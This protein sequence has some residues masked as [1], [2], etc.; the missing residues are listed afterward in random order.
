MPIETTRSITTTQA[1]QLLIT[2][3]AGLRE[4]GPPGD[5][6]TVSVTATVDG[7]QASPA[8]TTTTAPTGLHTQAVYEAVR[9]IGAGRH[10]VAI[11]IS[12]SG[13]AFAG[14]LT[15]QPITVRLIALP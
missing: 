4:S 11:T 8:E 3:S 7:H 5:A 12:I 6:A 13:A 1:G 14:V 9:T 10:Q 2:A 15:V